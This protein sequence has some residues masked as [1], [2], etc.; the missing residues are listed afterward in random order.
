MAKSCGA[1]GFAEQVELSPGVTIDGIIERP[2]TFEVIRNTARFQSGDQVND[3]FVISNRISIIADF[4]TREHMGVMRYVSYLG[5]RWK[6][7]NIEVQF[8]RLILDLGG[9][10]NGP[11]PGIANSSGDS[12]RK[13]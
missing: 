4:Y 8:P 13:S 2:Y 1:I 12:S 10:Y 7:T 9:V 3:D 11:T 5:T 6:I